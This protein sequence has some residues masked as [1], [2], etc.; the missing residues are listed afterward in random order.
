MSREREPSK[1]PGF[2]RNGITVSYYKGGLVS[3]AKT[4]DG[5]TVTIKHCT[6]PNPERQYFP[7]DKK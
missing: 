6:G 2:I 7:K 4:K 1:V 5:G 3:F